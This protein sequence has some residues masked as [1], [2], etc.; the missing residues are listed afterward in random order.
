MVRLRLHTVGKRRRQRPTLDKDNAAIRPAVECQIYFGIFAAPVSLLDGLARN[1]SRC[2]IEGA[3]FR[4][5]EGH[6]LLVGLQAVIADRHSAE[7]SVNGDK[8]HGI[9]PG[10]TERR[11]TLRELISF[12]PA[13]VFYELKVIRLRKRDSPWN[14]LESLRV[15]LHRYGLGPGW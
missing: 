6:N 5:E 1:L 10:R 14:S 8:P 7:L 3:M 12:H 4:F 2:P 13:A 15:P 11:R 9:N